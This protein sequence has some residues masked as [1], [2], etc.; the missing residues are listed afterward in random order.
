MNQ[1][2]FV[3]RNEAWWSAFDAQLSR[4]ET[5]R[6]AP[7]QVDEFAAQYRRLCQQLAVARHRHYG[8]DT[9]ERLNSLVL[10]AHSRLYGKNVEGYGASLRTAL[11]RFPQ[12]VRREW[13][14][15]VLAHC[16]FYLPALGMMAAV[17][18]WPELVQTVLGPAELAQLESMY[19]PKADHF[20]KERAFDSDVL[21][22]GYYIYNNIGI[23]FR[24]FASGIIGGLGSLFFLMFNGVFL[25]SAAGHLTTVGMGTTFWSFVITHGA[26]ELTAIVL[27]GAAGIR[28]GTAVLVPKNRTRSLALTEAVRDVMPIVW[29]FTAFLV[30]AAFLEAFWSSSRMV[31]NDVK[32]VVGGLAWLWVYLYLYLGGRGAMETHNGH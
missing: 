7:E 29:G 14:A 31:P 12:A 25:G 16:L 19:D 15:V 24:T 1:D 23:A 3:R 11:L 6:S 5:T 9:V 13:R 17:T 4:M 32:Q 2:V 21:M 8:A 18:G 27:S 30:A 22:F 20:L 26:F 28:L 10:R